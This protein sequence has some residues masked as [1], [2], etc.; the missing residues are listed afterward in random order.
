MEHNGAICYNRRRVFYSVE[1]KQC[2]QRNLRIE[3][4]DVCAGREYA[5]IFARNYYSALSAIE[6]FRFK[7]DLKLYKDGVVQK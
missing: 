3:F 5:E 6:K 1:N 7:R 2:I 4:I